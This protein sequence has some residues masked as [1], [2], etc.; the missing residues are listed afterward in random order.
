MQLSAK[1]SFMKDTLKNDDTN[2]IK[3]EITKESLQN[4]EKEK[5]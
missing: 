2:E 1:C 3:I 4:E 5:K